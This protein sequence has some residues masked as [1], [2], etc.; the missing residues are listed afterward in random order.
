MAVLWG[1]ARTGAISSAIV[2]VERDAPAVLYMLHAQ[3]LTQIHSPTQTWAGG[4]REHIC[5]CDR[6]RFDHRTHLDE[7]NVPI[8]DAR[9]LKQKNHAIPFNLPCLIVYFT[10]KSSYKEIL[11]QTKDG[12]FNGINAFHE[13]WI[14]FVVKSETI[15]NQLNMQWL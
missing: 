14:G 1:R 7:R 6:S 4:R 12:I 13:R 15:I 8:N 11:V 9:Y 3:I 2:C 5:G 10:T